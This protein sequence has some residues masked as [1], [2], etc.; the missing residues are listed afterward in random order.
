MLYTDQLDTKI[1]TEILLWINAQRQRD[2]TDLH[3][4]PMKD[5]NYLVEILINKMEEYNE[6]RKT[7]RSKRKYSKACED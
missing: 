6:A 2:V 3:L 5:I 7:N 4:I 1:R